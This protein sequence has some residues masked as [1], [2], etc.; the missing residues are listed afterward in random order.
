MTP[1]I[2]SSIRAFT[3]VELLV[4]IAIIGILVALLLPAIQAARE[5][6]RRTQC[7]NNL[8]NVGLACINHLDTLKVFPTG[9]AYWSP[10]L[11][12][13]IEGGRAAGPQK[14]GLGWGF[15]VLPY[16]EEDAIASLTTEAEISD[17][18]VPLYVCPS[19]R[20]LKKLY[21]PENNLTV[22]LTDYAGVHPCTKIWT[23]DALPLD[24]TTQPG[25]WRARDYFVKPSPSKDQPGFNGE[26]TSREACVPADGVYDGVI[27]RSPWRAD[28]GNYDY[29]FQKMAGVFASNVPNPITTAKISDGTSKSMLITEKY[30]PNGAYEG[31]SASD[32]RGWTDGWDSDT[33]RCTCIRPMNDGDNDSEHTGVPERNWNNVSFYTLV[34][35]SAH[36]SSFNAVFADGSVRSFNYDIDLFLLNALGTR[37]NTSAGPVIGG[38]VSAEVSTEGT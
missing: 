16:L 14:Q 18:T 37:N 35:G 8:K 13:F 17:T 12:Q 22:T 7:K 26:A 19:R 11:D 9:G 1:R 6:S 15:Q 33:M 36:P 5:A 29:Q 3:L 23:T 28:P 34:I 27:V 21:H 38:R 10:Q 2:K 25:A 4:V 30:L 24:L 32:D 20:G 31:G